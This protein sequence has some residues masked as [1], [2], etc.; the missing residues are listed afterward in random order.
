VK[1]VIDD[2]Y[3]LARVRPQGRVDPE[4]DER[5]DQATKQEKLKRAEEVDSATSQVAASGGDESESRTWYI[6]SG[7]RANG[8]WQLS[9]RNANT[10][11]GR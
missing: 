4:E 9:S 8:D 7:E 2:V 5:V 1:I 10:L 6:D 11:S 3:V